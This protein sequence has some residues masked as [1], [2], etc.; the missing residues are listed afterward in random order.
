MSRGPHLRCGDCR[1]RDRNGTC[2][3]RAKFMSA[4][5]KACDFG[6]AEHHRSMERDRANKRYHQ[7]NP[8]AAYKGS[9]AGRKGK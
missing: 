7:E 9:Y 5:A 8:T 4:L 6:K 1:R 3:V 2:L